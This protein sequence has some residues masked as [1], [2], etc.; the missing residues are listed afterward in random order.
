MNR[1]GFLKAAGSSVALT[2]SGCA[3]GAH[4]TARKSQP[5]FVVI[6]T[7]DQ[8]YNDLGCF[9]SRLIKTP[10][11]DRMAR[12]GMRF[13]DFHVSAPVC[14]PSRASLMTGCYAQRVGLAEVREKDRDQPSFVLFPFS[15]YGLNPSEITV[16]DLLHQ[17]GYTTACMGKWHLGHLPPFLP[18]RHGFDSYYGIPYSNDMKP[19]PILRNEEAIEEPAVQETLTERYTEEAVRFIGENRDRPFFLYLPHNMPHVPLHVSDRFR[20]KSAGGLY[21][22]VVECIDWSV[23]R[24]LDTLEALGLSDNTLVIFTTDNGP[25]LSQGENGGFAAPL[26]AGKGTTYEGGMRVPCVMRWP[27]AIP[28]DTVCTEF[29]TTMD[30]LPTL[31]RL[32]GGEAPT[33]RIIDGKDILS[34]MKGEAGAKS[35]Y[36]AFYYYYGNRLQAVRSGPWKL[37]LKSV[38]SQED[39]YKRFETPDAPVAEALYNLDTD[40]GEQ[41]SLLNDHPDVAERLRAIAEKARADLGDSIMGVPGANVRPAGQFS[42]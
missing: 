27:A 33:D 28:A 13:T 11:I 23:G 20:G 30:I 37:K 10:R 14:T 38:L 4:R 2:A 25:W 22:D 3:T 41:K 24:I 16:A 18:T 19:S 7:D 26:R 39:I 29:A 42:P 21:G 9:G 1:R 12:E 35:P 17:Q 5:N 36:D 8:G 40:I 31:T 34:L 15:T 6:F 32:A